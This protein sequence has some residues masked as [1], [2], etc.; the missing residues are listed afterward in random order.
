[1]EMAIV[2]IK[3]APWSSKA[4]LNVEVGDGIKPWLRLRAALEIVRRSVK[5]S[6]I[7]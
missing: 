4:A 1:M 5:A 6:E 2:E 3:F 7:S